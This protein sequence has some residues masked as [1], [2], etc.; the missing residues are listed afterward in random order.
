MIYPFLG[1]IV[2]IAVG[3]TGVGGTT[4]MTPLLLLTNI[5]PIVA[6]STGLLFSFVTKVVA[7]ALY[8]KRKRIN[9]QLVG[10]LCLGSIPAS[11]ITALFLK[12]FANAIGDNTIRLVIGITVVATAMLLLVNKRFISTN[13]DAHHKL[14]RPLRPHEYVLTVLC[15]IFVGIL[16]T[17]T[18]LGAGV[19]VIIFLFFF[20]PRLKATA[21]VGTD[22]VHA[23]ILTAIASLGHMFITTMDYKLIAW[24]LLGSLPGVYIGYWIG[25]IVSE[26]TMRL[27][28]AFALLAMG[29]VLLGH[30]FI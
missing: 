5:A 9:W 10:L 3:I 6:V 18:S 14:H 1:L 7:I 16:V 23:V 26:R 27:V 11:I 12:E 8:S 19:V 30:N 15:G 22:L 20:Y 25:K 29:L 2:G 4:L 13:H 17:I 21:I 24:L 28:I